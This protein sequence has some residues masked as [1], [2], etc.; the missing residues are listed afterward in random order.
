MTFD[1]Q[2]DHPEYG[3]ERYFVSI[4]EADKEGAEWRRTIS[5]EA[6]KE[7]EVRISYHNNCDPALNH[8]GSGIAIGLV[9]SVHVP[10]IVLPNRIE[11]IKATISCPVSTPSIL[12]A[13]ADIT[14]ASTNPMF[15]RWIVAS[16]RIHNQGDLNDKGLSTHLFENSGE[17]GMFLGFHRLD[18]R[19][20]AGDEYS[21]HVTF[22]FQAF[23]PQVICVMKRFAS[24]NGGEYTRG[25]IT[26]HPGDT[27]AFR[28]EFKNAGNLILSN[29]TFKDE[30]G[31][32][33][34]LVGNTTNY[35]DSVG[36][37]QHLSDLIDKNGYNFGNYGVG[38]SITIDYETTVPQNAVPG[39]FRT[40]SHIYHN[41][42]GW[43]D[44]LDVTIE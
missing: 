12:W 13:G 41:G 32:S 21:G 42:G 18:G 24:V 23:Q 20:P 43:S 36:N 28:S 27:V 6:G 11:Q 10:D 26:V 5:L 9:L 14:A 40:I 2:T 3:D 4:R 16:A 19:L 17:A 31:G 38:V 44:A 1:S 39:T 7:Y 22:R 15:L 8:T 25:R 33:L 30:L 35:S 29:L 34:A 37:T